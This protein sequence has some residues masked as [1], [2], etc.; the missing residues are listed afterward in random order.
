MNLEVKR[1]MFT[2][3]QWTISKGYGVRKRNL[4]EEGKEIWK[5]GKKER[6]V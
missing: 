4:K 5:F 6:G 2:W 1:N 3:G